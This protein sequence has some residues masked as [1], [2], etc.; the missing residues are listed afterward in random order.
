MIPHCAGVAP[1]PV[2]STLPPAPEARADSGRFGFVAVA[3]AI[4]VIASTLTRIGL[5]AISDVSRAS[6]ALVARA[7]ATGFLYDLVVAFWVTAPFMA[8]LTFA[9]RKRYGR[10]VPRVFRRVWLGGII[11]LAAFTVAAE[12]VFWSEFDGRFNF[13]AVDYLI[14]PTEVFTNIWQS[15]PLVWV[16]VGIGTVTGVTLWLLRR[17]LA[18]FDA[19]DGPPASRRLLVGFVYA[20]VL[21]AVTY[22][23]PADMN[24]VSDDRVLNEVAASGYYTFFQ[25]LLGRVGA[26][27]FDA[28][29]EGLY[30]TRPDS[31][32]FARLRRLQSEPA[33]PP[34][35]ARLSSAAAARGGTP[36]RPPNVVLVLIES[37]GSDFVSELHPRDSLSI[38]PSFD[39]LTAEGTLL[40]HAY[41][42]GNRTIRAIEA[43]S[44]SIPPLPGVSVV[45]RPPSRGLFSLAATLRANGYQTEFVYGGRALF[46]G[47][48]TYERANGFDHVFDQG[49]FPKGSFTTAWGVADEVIFDGALAQMDSMNATGRP[50]YQMILTVSNHKPYTYPPGRIPQ[51][52]NEHRRTFAVHYTDWAIGRFM[53]AARSHAFFDNTIF[54]LMGDHGARVYGAAEIPLPSY[55]VPILFYGPKFF[56]AG[57]R[58]RTVASSLDIP[59]TVLSLA[60]IRAETPF[61]G[62]DVFAADTSRGR[63]LMTHNNDLVLMRGDRM[64][65]LG[66]HGS[67]TLYSVDATG[68]LKRIANPDAADH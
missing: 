23:L 47:M 50:F 55:E 11:A 34:S 24:R 16:I 13:V 19:V 5:Y 25:A 32:L 35:P 54:I 67:T 38:T 22:A 4:I 15:Y 61:F 42:T 1:N 9:S 60:G 52:P 64:A 8:Y 56:A 46:D 20:A 59:P 48:G 68:K 31:E 14:F 65:V 40:T 17:R 26:V 29:Y 63:A 41:S 7:F 62:Q 30:A 33:T 66:L 10:T 58:V 49:Q 53:R 12:F 3:A 37:F 27:A 45:Q 51:N 36:P 2:S 28:P 6:P 57:G 39:S 18:R 43:T 44:V 21:G